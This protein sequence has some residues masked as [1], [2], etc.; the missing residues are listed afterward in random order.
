MRKIHYTLPD[1]EQSQVVIRCVSILPNYAAKKGFL[2]EK[3]MLRWL[4]ST[5]IDSRI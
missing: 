3:W 4:P 1:E 5:L 2:N